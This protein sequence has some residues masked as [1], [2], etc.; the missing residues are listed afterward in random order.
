LSD[1]LGGHL[2]SGHIDGTGTVSRS[3]QEDNALW[4]RINAGAGLLKYIITKGSVAIDGI[5]LT[6]AGTDPSGFTVSLI[7]HT[8]SVTTLAGRKQGDVVNIECDLFAKYVE[9]LA[10][11]DG[12]HGGIDREFL[13]KHGY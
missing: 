7:P 4:F 5:S 2:L 9:K 1:R 10:E 13:A 11:H 3:W 6:V 8:R 12:N